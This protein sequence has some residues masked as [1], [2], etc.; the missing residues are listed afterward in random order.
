MIDAIIDEVIEREGGSEVTNKPNDPG[1][2]TQYGISERS[3]PQAWLDG[4]VTEK[5]AREIYIQ[6]YVIYPKFHTI[7]P[8]H[9]RLQAQLIDFGVHSGQAT[10]IMKLQTLLDVDVDGKLGPQTLQAIKNHDPRILNNNLVVARVKMVGKIVQ[11]NP[12]QLSDLSGFLN[13]ALSFLIS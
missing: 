11:K 8:S 3:N 5:E 12:R 1:G 10:A 2:R 4:K 9:A 13:R 6:K 7:P